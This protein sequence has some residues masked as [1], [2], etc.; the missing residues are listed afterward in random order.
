M[1]PQ[2]KNQQCRSAV[3]FVASLLG[4]AGCVSVA[5]LE[6][7]KNPPTYFRSDNTVAVEF[8]APA[9]VGV[10]CAERGTAF[11]GMPV[12]HAMACGNGKLITMPE[13]CATFTGGAYAALV[14]DTRRDVKS[15]RDAVSPFLVNAS[16]IAGKTAAFETEETP[17]EGGTYKVEFVHPASVGMRCSL[18]GAPMREGEED[19]LRACATP[20]RMILPNPCMSLEAGWYPR[21]LCHE[22]AH[23]NGWAMDHP[24]GSFQSDK[25]AGIDPADVPPPQFVMASL[26]SG[27]PLRK[28]SE[29]PTYLAY[30]AAKGLPDTGYASLV[31]PAVLTAETVKARPPVP[32]L[33]AALKTAQ[34]AVPDF[35]A[36]SRVFLAALQTPVPVPATS[37]APERRR[38][39]ATFDPI[40]VARLYQAS[41][42]MPQQTPQAPLKPLHLQYAAL[43]P[44]T[45]AAPAQVLQLAFTVASPT[46]SIG[47]ATLD[48]GLTAHGA[49]VAVVG[50]AENRVA[51]LTLPSRPS[52]P[53]AGH[54][55]LA[56]RGKA[57]LEPDMPDT[58]VAEAALPPAPAAPGLKPAAPPAWREDLQVSPAAG[59]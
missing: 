5:P 54:T 4:L 37:G 59:V 30:A 55:A 23:A 49:S 56:L 11:F 7:I 24:G 16:F 33:F 36:D 44:V 42:E 27:A 58:S 48:A 21:T 3:V 6:P 46:E 53:P 32:A 35:V 1:V 19:S 9:V 47:A 26:S 25:K 12:F 45:P 14:C 41:L 40:A 39:A 15:L 57:R 38:P 22:M 28:A 51:E 29:S 50:G 43:E 2:N 18:L 20:E 8:L 52:V 34:A 17:S 31:Q 13:A 10:R